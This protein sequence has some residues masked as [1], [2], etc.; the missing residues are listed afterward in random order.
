MFKKKR[1]R[2]NEVKRGLKNS[3]LKET[4]GKDVLY[5]NII[6]IPEINNSS[7]IFFRADR[8]NG[9]TEQAEQNPTVHHSPLSLIIPSRSL[10]TR[11]MS[12]HL[13]S[14]NPQ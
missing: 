8:H 5:P 9:K 14:K 1:P 10:P 13:P 6:K 3:T 4:C 11:T 7:P 2:R 12:T